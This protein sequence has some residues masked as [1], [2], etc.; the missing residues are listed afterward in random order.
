MR[1]FFFIIVILLYINCLIIPDNHSP[2]YLVEPNIDLTTKNLI[3]RFSLKESPGIGYKQFFAI[4]FPKDINK[5]DLGFE[6]PIPGTINSPKFECKLRYIK[7]LFSQE[8]KVSSRLSEEGAYSKIPA[9]TNIMYCQI[10]DL[11]FK[12]FDDEEVKYELKIILKQEL[13]TLNFKS[14][15]LLLTTTNNPDKIILDRIHFLNN[16]CLELLRKLLAPI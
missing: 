12:T 11:N 5:F 8:V 14:I 2:V 1:N 10:D 16:T 7:G 4:V 9:E 6:R 3:T 13:Q 15:S